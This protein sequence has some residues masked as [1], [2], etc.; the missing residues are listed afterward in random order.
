M[1]FNVLVSDPLAK[2]G[3]DILTGF[4]D[5]AEKADLSDDALVTFIGV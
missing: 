2:E 5:V 4:C 1:S 3:V